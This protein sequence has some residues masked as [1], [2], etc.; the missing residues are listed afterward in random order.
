MKK[1]FMF[2]LVTLLSSQAIFA[3]TSDKS[4][5]LKELNDTAK[6]ISKK[7]AKVNADIDLSS[8]MHT[9]T[10]EQKKSREEGLKKFNEFSVKLLNCEKTEIK[11][12]ENNTS[13][14]ILGYSGDNCI[15]ETINTFDNGKKMIQ[16]CTLPKDRLEELVEYTRRSIQEPPKVKYNVNLDMKMPEVKFND[17]SKDNIDF[18]VKLQMPKIEIKETKENDLEKLIQE[19]CVNTEE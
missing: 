18:G 15:V 6:E 7:T 4:K 14:S 19:W 11:M 12:A 2:S 5:D 13:V 3:Q 9:E 8:F 1:I 10:E 16:K 17:L